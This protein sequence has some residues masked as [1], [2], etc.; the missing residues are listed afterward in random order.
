[1]ADVFGLSKETVTSSKCIGPHIWNL[2]MNGLIIGQCSPF[3]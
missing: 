3:P 1:M 2:V